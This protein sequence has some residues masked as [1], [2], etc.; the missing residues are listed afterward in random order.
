MRSQRQ[1]KRD[2]EPYTDTETKPETHAEG[3]ME[4]R[5]ST[6]AGADPVYEQEETSGEDEGQTE[7][8]VPREGEGWGEDTEKLREEWE[9]MRVEMERGRVPGYDE[10]SPQP[11]PYSPDYYYLKVRTQR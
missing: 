8:G 2:T 10:K 7:E 6:E 3:V 11:Y 1:E 4:E 5:V 9:R